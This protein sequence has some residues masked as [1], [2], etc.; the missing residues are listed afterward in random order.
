VNAQRNGTRG[1]HKVVDRDS[2]FLVG[3]SGV[4]VFDGFSRSDKTEITMPFEG[5][6]VVIRKEPSF[7]AARRPGAGVQGTAAGLGM[8]GL[9]IDIVRWRPSSKGL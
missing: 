5:G 9:R 1:F 6:R 4:V 2:P 7:A 8:T 3:A